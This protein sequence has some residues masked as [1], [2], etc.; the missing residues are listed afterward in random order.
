MLKFTKFTDLPIY[1]I[2][3]FTKLPIYLPVSKYKKVAQ[4]WKPCA[5]IS[6]IMLTFADDLRDKV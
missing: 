4:L 5:N 3:R 1:Q 6:K 2:Y